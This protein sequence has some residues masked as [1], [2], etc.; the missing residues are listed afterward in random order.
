MP[1]LFPLRCPSLLIYTSSFSLS[2]QFTNPNG[3]SSVFSE[4]E[5]SETPQAHRRMPSFSLTSRS[6]LL[7]V[8]PLEQKTNKPK[9][10][11]KTTAIDEG[12]DD[13]RFFGF[14]VREL[15]AIKRDACLGFL[16]MNVIHPPDGAFWGKFNNR[17]VDHPWIKSMSKTFVNC[18]DSCTDDHSMDLALDP[19]WL[20][21]PNS[22]CPT[23]EGLSIH[24]VPVVKFNQQG[25]LA[26]KNK[27][28][29][30]LG[31]NHRRL[32]LARYIDNMKDDVERANNLIHKLT[33]GKDS[34][35]IRDMNPEDTT[36]L[37]DARE[38]VKSLL[39]KIDSS[40]MWSVK[41]YDRGL[42]YHRPARSPSLTR[43]P[44]SQNRAGKLRGDR[45][46]RLPTHF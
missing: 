3:S 36:K 40:C 18:L 30:V 41:V 34:D 31:G 23:V 14:S 7:P 9:K 2:P 17:T 1:L 21:T 11:K 32:A 20:N 26:I 38:R 24:D 15:R 25:K 35:Q 45:Q 39:E 10:D 22:M 42:S 43:S 12:L 44:Y 6:V 19:E 29:W 27:N 13:G 33:A 46:G 5:T 28:L 37:E 8:N 16:S 4:R